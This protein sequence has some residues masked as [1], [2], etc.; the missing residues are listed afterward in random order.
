MASP[1]MASLEIGVAERKGEPRRKL[2]ERASQMLQA[3]G[4]IEEWILAVY[5][6]VRRSLALSACVSVR[7]S[8]YLSLCM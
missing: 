8:V 2:E 7:V 3:R 6:S 4:R 5:R 1:K